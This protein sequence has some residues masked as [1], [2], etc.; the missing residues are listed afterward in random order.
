MN[1]NFK[2]KNLKKI[3]NISKED[4]IK[5]GISVSNFAYMI[6][7]ELELDD[8]MCYEISMAGVLHD[9]GK[10]RLSGYLNGNDSLT[11]EEDK[12]MRLH[13]KLSYEFLKD[14]DVSDFILD[15]ILYHHENYDGS[16]YPENLKGEEIPIG[17]RILRVSDVFAALLSDRTYRKKFDVNTAIQIMIDEVNDF[18]MNIFLAFQRVINESELDQLL[19]EEERIK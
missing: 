14:R 8:N 16:G 7:K 6:A 11:F 2:K 10:L 3:L 4:V 13:S 1:F 18:D 5:H 17:A 12:Y 9:I 19:L 15:S